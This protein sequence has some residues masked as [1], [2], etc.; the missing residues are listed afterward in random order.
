[1]ANDLLLSELLLKI[2][3]L[4]RIVEAQVLEISILKK[5][6]K[7]LRERLEKY[8]NPKNSRNSSIAP[9]MDVN[10][11][12]KNQSLRKKTN[13]K[14][15]GQP[16]HKGTTLKK[17][18]TPDH[19]VELHPDYCN[20]CGSSLL[21]LPSVFAK[22]RQVVDIPPIKAVWTEYRTYATQCNCGCCTRSDFPKGVTSP[23][24]YG[25]SIEG[26]IA[27]FHA[28]Q[29]IP[30]K[31]MKEIMTDVMGVNISEGGIHY[32]LARFASRTTP[33]Y[34]SIRKRISQATV[35][36][37]DETGVK[38]NGAKHWF[39]AWQNILLT[40]IAHCA[41][42]G[43]FA[44]DTHFPYGFPNATLIRDGWRPQINTPAKHHQTCLAH[45]LRDLNYL[46]EINK[47][48]GW[49]KKFKKLLYDAM[50]YK[51]KK[52]IEQDSVEKSKIIHRLEEL[53]EQPP[54]NNNKELTTFYKRMCRERQNLF[55]FL[56]VIGVPCDN[57]GSERTIRMV[58]VKQKIS[59]QFKTDT[60]A[61][62]FAKVRSVIDTTVKNGMNVMQALNLIAK[63]QPQIR[64]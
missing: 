33:I 54:Q 45:I 25:T 34:E 38:V 9:S 11:P 28:R 48:N 6:N 59:G 39:W 19:I 41:T 27:Y 2:T 22:S 14:V 5:E 1:M 53:L 32:L 51:A 7:E 18:N 52:N 56:F 24:G 20:Q 61:Q 55:T 31:R 63:L 23:V 58:K 49:P 30:F 36:G 3:H 42:R 17:T 64:N 57:N 13:R 62:N 44:I 26:L 8:E 15:G 43:K 21:G 60:T 37:S 29:Y 12:K 10:R 50:A 16:G 4:T 46:I 47:D 40:Y 35:V